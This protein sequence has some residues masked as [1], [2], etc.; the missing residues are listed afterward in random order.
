MNDVCPRAA[1]LIV[2]VRCLSPQPFVTVRMKATGVQQF[3]DQRTF[4]DIC[5]KA[6]AQ[7]EDEL[8]QPCNRFSLDVP[9]LFAIKNRLYEFFGVHDEIEGVYRIQDTPSGKG[10][11]PS[12][13]E[14]TFGQA[15]VCA[16][17]A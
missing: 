11:Q 4:T 9:V 12:E 3:I 6:W 10:L 5:A 1:R 2:A 16:K 13:H 8:R 7:A 15:Y 14:K 17:L